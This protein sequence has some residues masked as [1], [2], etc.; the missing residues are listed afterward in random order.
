MTKYSQNYRLSTEQHLPY[1]YEQQMLEYVRKGDY[2]AF[3]KFAREQLPTS[4]YSLGEVSHNNLKQ[5]EYYAIS[6]IILFTR[7]HPVA[8]FIVRIF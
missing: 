6:Q 4:S 7:A 3:E 5:R 1:L 2:E 8:L